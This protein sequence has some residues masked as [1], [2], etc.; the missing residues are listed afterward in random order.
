LEVKRILS[1]DF[2]DSLFLDFENF[3]KFAIADTLKGPDSSGLCRWVLWQG[4]KN[5]YLGVVDLSIK[6]IFSEAGCR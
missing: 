2:F 3:P 4:I 6:F 5:Q 1:A